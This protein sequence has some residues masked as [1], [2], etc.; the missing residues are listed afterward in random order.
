MKNKIFAKA[1]V[2]T[3]L[4]LMLVTFTHCL[5]N[6]PVSGTGATK[7]SPS[8]ASSNV[9]DTPA[10][11]TASRPEQVLNL[12]QVEV[13]VKNHEQLLYT[14]SELTGISAMN[15]SIKTT[16][17]Q[18][19]SSLP[20]S[21]DVK[22]F[23]APNQV[24]ITRLAAEYCGLLIDN[25]VV[26]GIPTRRQEIWPAFGFN[27]T[28]ANFNQSQQIMV[29]T[30]MIHAFWGTDILTPEEEDSAIDELMALMNNL[31]VGESTTSTASTNKIIKGACTSALS[32]AYV[33]VM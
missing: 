3:F 23:L 21:N 19:A 8:S 13:G 14:Y 22:T 29:L 6:A 10:A 11:P 26:D 4:S 5:S 9:V 27:V 32:S 31:A 2:V 30:N 7:R 18:V 24:A 25:T 12:A 20:S 33:S 1:F 16:Y 17:N 28:L 15:N